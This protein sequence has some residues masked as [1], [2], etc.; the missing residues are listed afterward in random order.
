MRKN[1][2]ICGKGCGFSGALLKCRT[3]GK[4]F[5]HRHETE[6]FIKYSIIEGYSYNYPDGESMKEDF[7][8]C[9][10]CR[11]GE[12]P[13][14]LGNR[15]YTILE[16]LI[17]IFIIAGIVLFTILWVISN[18]GENLGLSKNIIDK[19]QVICIPSVIVYI[20]LFILIVTYFH[21]KW[22]SRM[23]KREQ[24]KD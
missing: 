2:S 12:E 23:K 20:I 22:K 5:C 3:C 10:L 21:I 24:M 11:T 16:Y 6:Q 15:G 4:I 1:C 17:Q 14:D 13:K 9:Y 18:W 19:S 7:F 8:Q